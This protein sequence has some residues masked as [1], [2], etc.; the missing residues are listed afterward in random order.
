MNYYM[1]DYELLVE[2]TI[3]KSFCVNN[4]E[5]FVNRYFSN[6]YD[7]DYVKHAVY[8]VF[9]KLYNNPNIKKNNNEYLITLVK[10]YLYVSV[11]TFLLR[12][13]VSLNYEDRIT[14]SKLGI[15]NF[16]E[17]NDKELNSYNLS[18]FYFIS[19]TRAAEIFNYANGNNNKLSYEDVSYSFEDKLV[20]YLDN[21][22]SI[23]LLYNQIKKK[24][25][26]IIFYLRY[27]KDLTFVDIAQV[28]N[29]TPQAIMDKNDRLIKKLV[30]DNNL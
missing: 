22:K 12:D 6:F 28:L 3:R 21:E 27:I 23:K 15:D 1:S 8:I 10:K 13:F 7:K 24:D 14:I 26:R 19:L 2:N 4:V 29:C 17:K 16:L 5:E 30:K 18:K 20:N 25:Y 11:I 9:N